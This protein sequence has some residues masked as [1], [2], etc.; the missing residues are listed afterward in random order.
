MNGL[1]ALIVIHP[2]RPTPSRRTTLLGWLGLPWLIAVLFGTDAVLELIGLPPGERPLPLG[3]LLV[4]SALLPIALYVASPWLGRLPA[5][6][7]LLA[8]PQPKAV[9]DAEGIRLTLPERTEAR[10][11]S[12]SAHLSLSGDSRPRHGG[13]WTH[14]GLAPC[15]ERHVRIRD[16]IGMVGSGDRV[17]SRPAACAL[18]VLRLPCAPG[19][20][21][22]SQDVS[23]SPLIGVVGVL[24]VWRYVGRPL[25]RHRR[26][27]PPRARS[28]DQGPPPHPLVLDTRLDGVQDDATRGRATSSDGVSSGDGDRSR[29]AWCHHLPSVV[30]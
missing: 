25:C 12:S 14:R 21:P 30:A 18:A 2:S 13:R 6:G 10:L 17:D 5:M 19:V 3:M 20:G 9:L 27:R 24:P 22:R 26:R 4:A 28:S 7:W 8:K 23:V 29:C 16:C 15:N 1:S 11:R